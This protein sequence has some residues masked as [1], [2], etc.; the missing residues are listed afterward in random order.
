MKSF[1]EAPEPLTRTQRNIVIG[2]AVVVALTRIAALSRTLWDWDE[3]LFCMGVRE[4]DVPSHHPHP[5]GYPLFVAA[6]KLVRLVIHNDFRAVQAV[7][8]IAACALFP[9]LF[10]LARE[11]RFPFAVAAGGAALYA[12]FPNVWHY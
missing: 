5:P 2:I 7:V 8:L 4:Y 10:A 12:F 3:A 9:A 1:A 11:L 6:A